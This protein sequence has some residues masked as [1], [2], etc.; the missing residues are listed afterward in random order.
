MTNF[1]A[2]FNDF[3]DA[4]QIKSA[5]GK[6]NKLAAKMTDSNNKRERTARVES[7]FPLDLIKPCWRRVREFYAN[8]EIFIGMSS[9][10]CFFEREKAFSHLA[11]H[12]FVNIS[13][14]KSKRAPGSIKE[15]CLPKTVVGHNGM[16]QCHPKKELS[17]IKL[18][19]QDV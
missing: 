3:V 15:A 16:S 13:Q 5:K 14:M 10:P 7:I 18:G 1:E 11:I 2:N 4:H 12:Y 9:A 6:W 19:A 17:A 8:S